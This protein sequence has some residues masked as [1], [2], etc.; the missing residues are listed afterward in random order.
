MND[1][2]CALF[3]LSIFKKHGRGAFKEEWTAL[4][5]VCVGYWIG[6]VPYSEIWI[7]FWRGFN[8]EAG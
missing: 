7:G 1:V 4:F 6:Q 3:I 8:G 2:V 5:W